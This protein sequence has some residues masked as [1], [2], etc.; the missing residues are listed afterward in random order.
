MPQKR[1]AHKIMHCQKNRIGLVDDVA[2]C[3]KKQKGYAIM[4]N[5]NYGTKHDAAKIPVDLFPEEAIL[6]ISE[7]L[8]FGAAKYGRHNWRQGIVY[9]RVYAAALRHLLAWSAGEQCDSESGLSHLAHAG[10]C[11]AFLL[12]FEKT[13]PDLDDR[14][15][16]GNK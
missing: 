11:V 10:A 4:K 8:A 13:R 16:G 9:S 12:E 1:I 7:V 6:R 3:V 2:E 5:A 15:K 14:W